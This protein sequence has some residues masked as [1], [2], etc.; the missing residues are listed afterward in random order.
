MDNTELYE[1][2]E[3]YENMD[4]NYDAL[5]VLGCECSAGNDETKLGS[6]PAC[7]SEFDA[8]DFVHLVH[9]SSLKVWVTHSD[10]LEPG[11]SNGGH[12]R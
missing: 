3:L 2:I 12:I 4:G 11:S 5:I 7:S 10:N 9:A 6:C 8:L 1:N